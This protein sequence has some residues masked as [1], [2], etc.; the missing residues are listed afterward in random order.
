MLEKE[1]IFEHL[2]R[3]ETLPTDL[4]IVCSDLHPLHGGV[5]FELSAGKMMYRCQDRGGREVQSL[6]K[7]LPEK[8]LS[9][10]V[11]L[12]VELEVW[13]PQAM[14]RPGY[15]DEVYVSLS[16]KAAGHEAQI[17]E[18]YNDLQKNNRLV[19]VVRKLEEI[20]SVLG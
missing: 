3:Q 2:L 1:P 9:Q 11:A 7:S 20:L 14:G 12:L 5:T 8:Y 13:K 6:S 15:P 16:I 18:W 19:L 10:I 17:G 4:V